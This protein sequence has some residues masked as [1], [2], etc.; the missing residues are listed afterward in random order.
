MRCLILG[1]S[2]KGKIYNLKPKVNEFWRRLYFDDGG[3]FEDSVCIATLVISTKK[4]IITLCTRKNG[5]ALKLKDKLAKYILKDFK[6]R[7]GSYSNEI[8]YY[9]NKG[10]IYNFN[11]YRVGKNEDFCNKEL[12]E[13]TG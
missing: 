12:L 9:N 2:V 4:G 13:I 11:D 7:S 10:I 5:E 8:I 1:V 3:N 6:V